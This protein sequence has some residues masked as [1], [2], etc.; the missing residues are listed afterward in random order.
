MS[1]LKNEQESLSLTLPDTVP[2]RSGYGDVFS[3]LVIILCIALGLQAYTGLTKYAALRSHG[4][5]AEGRWADRY[6]DPHDGKIYV[7]YY[8]T[9]GYKTYRNKQQVPDDMPYTNGG[10]VSIIYL[11][12][13]PYLSRIAGTEDY[14]KTD[15]FILAFCTVIN[16]LSVQ[17]LI[18][19]HTQRSAWL[20]QIMAFAKRKWN[21]QA[22]PVL[23]QEQIE[24]KTR[25]REMRK[26]RNRQKIK[27]ILIVG[28]SIFAVVFML[29]VINSIQKAISRAK[30]ESRAKRII[31]EGT[32]QEFNG[33]EMVLVPAGCFNM[34]NDGE[35]GQQCFDEPFWIDRY[36]VS[37]EQY[38]STGC[39]DS[40]SQPKQ[41]R[42]CVSW[43][44]AH[45]FCESRG[46]RLPTEAEWEY[47]ARGPDN[48]IYPWGN[49]FVADNVIHHDNSKG[50]TAAVGSRSGGVSWAGAYD[51]SGNVWEWTSTLYRNYP[52]DADDGRELYTMGNKQHI[53]RGGSFENTEGFL[54]ATFRFSGSS[55]YVDDIRGFRCVRSYSKP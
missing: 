24:R 51:M 47:A 46:A 35:G 26:L 36:E 42:N 27:R 50:Q 52:Y 38:G 45:D 30:Y 10:P 33:V 9:G 54:P 23:S 40:S 48:L 37:N 49:D 20:S 32:I 22:K 15:A 55:G 31:S 8:F 43:A 29:L 5:I 16:I 12:D 2:E 1:Y 44:D 19:Y 7:I 6:T 21:R 41:P 4:V 17:Y 25:Q 28:I 14:Q 11:P 53:L 39:V 13:N 18:A 34:G 3:I